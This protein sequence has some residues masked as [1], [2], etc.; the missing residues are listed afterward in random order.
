MTTGTNN[1]VPSDHPLDLLANAMNFDTA[2][3]TAADSFTDR[4]GVERMSWAGMKF[5]TPRTISQLLL[6]S[7]ATYDGYQCLCTGTFEGL[8]FSE[9]NRW[10]PISGEIIIPGCKYPVSDPSGGTINAGSSGTITLTTTLTLTL[11]MGVWVYLPAIATTPAITAGYHFVIMSSATVGTIYGTGTGESLPN[12]NPSATPL[13]VTV[14]AI[15]YTGSV[16]EKTLWSWTIPAGLLGDRGTADVQMSFARNASGSQTI[17]FN[18]KL[19]TS[20]VTTLSMATSNL[21]ALLYSHIKNN[22]AAYQLKNGTAFNIYQTASQAYTL[23]TENTANEL[24]TTLTCDKNDAAPNDW[25]MLLSSELR[26][27]L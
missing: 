9:G 7:P 15:A 21:G 10:K 25:G 26:I 22:G 24:T 1:A 5:L 19:G 16:T 23:I 17:V 3:N 14:G 2:M 18:R 8:W 13:T 12:N 27:K 20:T 6:L 4:F 11:G